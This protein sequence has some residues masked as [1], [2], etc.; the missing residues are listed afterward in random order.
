[1]DPATI[2]ASIAASIAVALVFLF[3]GYR[4]GASQTSHRKEK[5]WHRLEKEARKDAVKRSR[6]ILS[7][8]FSEQIAPYF[9]DFN[10]SPTSPSKVRTSM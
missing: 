3:L 10:H 9:P 4:A 7:G 6:S 1:M 2:A 5:E 8:N